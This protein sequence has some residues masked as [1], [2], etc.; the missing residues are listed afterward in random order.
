MKKHKISKLWISNRYFTFCNQQFKVIIS[1][2]ITKAK[3]FLHEKNK[4]PFK[5]NTYSFFF[6]LHEN[7][8]GQS[9]IKYKNHM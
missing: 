7:L 6:P 1:G 9:W 4:A 8:F 2:G 5:I 3:V